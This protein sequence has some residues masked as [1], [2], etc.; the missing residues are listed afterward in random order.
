MTGCAIFGDW[1]DFTI[2]A[3]K[4]IFFGFK[5]AIEVPFLKKKQYLL[6]LVGS[7]ETKAEKFIVL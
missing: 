3:K 1:S 4:N 6:V 5:N 2:V 7:I